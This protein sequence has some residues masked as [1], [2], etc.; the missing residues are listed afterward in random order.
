MMQQGD[1]IALVPQNRCWFVAIALT[2]RSPTW[3]RRL[4][5]KRSTARRL[6]QSSISKLHKLSASKSIR[7]WSSLQLLEKHHSKPRYNNPALMAWRSRQGSRQGWNSWHEDKS[8][9]GPSQGRGKKNNGNNRSSGSEPHGLPAYDQMGT[10]LPDSSSGAASSSPLPEKVVELLL[11][12]S[13][14]DA[15]IAQRL[16]GLLPDK[17]ADTEMRQQQQLLNRIRKVKQR[18]QK[19]EASLTTK[20]VQLK[21]FLEQVRVHVKNEKDRYQQETSETKKELEELKLELQQLRD[22][23]LPN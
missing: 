19:K 4:R 20:E 18:I 16:E 8:D 12:A 5:R 2:S 13:Q 21:N 9:K 3:H 6:V 23:H 10:G 1:R 15:K 17:A 11:E 22:G 14:N 7:L